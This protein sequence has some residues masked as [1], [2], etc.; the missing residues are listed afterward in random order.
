MEYLGFFKIIKIREELVDNLTKFNFGR[1]KNAA[2]FENSNLNFIFGH[3][4]DCNRLNCFW[5]KINHDVITVIREQFWIGSV[6]F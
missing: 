3:V 4:T 2:H 5:L 6:W 1:K